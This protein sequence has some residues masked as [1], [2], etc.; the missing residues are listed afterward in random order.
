MRHSF[1]GLMARIGIVE[2]EDTSGSLITVVRAET[3]QVSHPVRPYRDGGG[4][5]FHTDGCELVGLLCWSM[6]ATGGARSLAATQPVL[7]EVRE[8]RP[9]LYELLKDHVCP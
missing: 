1:L 2:A 6:P 7:D 9:D 8:R 4:Q 5:P 3:G